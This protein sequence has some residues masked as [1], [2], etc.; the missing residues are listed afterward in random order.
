MSVIFTEVSGPVEVRHLSE[1]GNL[2][3]ILNT[4]WSDPSSART[5]RSV[6]L[7]PQHIGGAES[8]RR[9]EK[10]GRL[11]TTINMGMMASSITE[12]DSHV[13]PAVDR[14][15]HRD[16]CKPR[17]EADDKSVAEMRLQQP[18]HPSSRQSSHQDTSAVKSLDS[19]DDSCAGD[20]GDA[21]DASSRRRHPFERV[22]AFPEPPTAGDPPVAAS[23]MAAA[24]A[25]R[26]SA[27]ATATATVSA[28]APA[29][30]SASASAS[31]A[32]AAASLPMPRE[33]AFPSS[34][35][36]HPI[37]LHTPQLYELKLLREACN[38]FDDAARSL[39][40]LEHALVTAAIGD[41]VSH[42]LLRLHTEAQHEVASQRQLR[43]QILEAMPWRRKGEHSQS[44]RATMPS[45]NHAHEQ[46]CPTHSRAPSLGPV[47]DCRGAVF[48]QALLRSSPCRHP[49]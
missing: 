36:D 28:S 8:Y 31:A 23:A 41:T 3:K 19:Y 6:N 14:E 46:P 26:F 30:A 9:R 38:G 44:G 17:Q 47:V 25:A 11:P 20:A 27:T 39:H 15:P 33:V 37:S 16:A 42:D 22:V 29:P 4:P 48:E 2:S 13:S 12:T 5:V 43:S 49:S 32:H 34:S 1:V 40:V 7:Q 21:D 18:S 45:S 24:A 10:S 35:A